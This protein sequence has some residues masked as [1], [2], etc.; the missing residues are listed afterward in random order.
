MMAGNIVVTVPIIDYL[1]MSGLGKPGNVSDVVHSSA[2]ATYSQLIP[3]SGDAQVN[4]SDVVLVYSIQF[5]GVLSG[6]VGYQLSGVGQVAGFASQGIE[7][8]DIMLGVQGRGVTLEVQNTS[9]QDVVYN[10]DFIAIDKDVFDT[11]I[12][13]LL[14]SATIGLRS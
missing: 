1:I 2:T 9:G 7:V 4:P 11:R 8:R 5:D 13:P 14:D 10:A 12:R 3:K 6:Q